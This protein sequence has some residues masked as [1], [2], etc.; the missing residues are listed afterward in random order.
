MRSTLTADVR[1]SGFCAVFV[2]LQLVK[3]LNEVYTHYD[4]LVEK[5]GLYKVLGQGRAR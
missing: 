4:S 2:P 3:M 1:V 5:H